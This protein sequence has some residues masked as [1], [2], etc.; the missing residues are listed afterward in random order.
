MIKAI[1][2]FEYRYV[3]NRP[4][5]PGSNRI[6]KLKKSCDNCFEFLKLCNMS[7]GLQCCEVCSKDIEALT[8]RL[9][10]TTERD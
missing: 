2:G 6:L 8:N 9:P 1:S 5:V 10:P 7:N 4:I 3:V